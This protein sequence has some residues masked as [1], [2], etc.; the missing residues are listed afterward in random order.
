[1][2]LVVKKLMVMRLAYF[3]LKTYHNGAYVLILDGPSFIYIFI[4]TYV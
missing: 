4:Y 2:I 3:T 1:M